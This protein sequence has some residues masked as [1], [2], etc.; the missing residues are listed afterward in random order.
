MGARGRAWCL[1]FAVLLC[2]V[3]SAFAQVVVNEVLPDPAGSDGGQEFVELYNPSG[4]PVSL[5][6][7]VVESWHGARRGWLRAWTGT[8]TDRC[9]ARGFFVLGGD[10]VTARVDGAFDETLTN[11]SGAVRVRGPRGVWSVVG[12]GALDDRQ[13]FEDTPAPAPGSAHSLS[14]VPDGANSGRTGADFLVTDAPTPGASNGRRGPVFASV[15]FAVAPGLPWPRRAATVRVRLGVV[16]GDAAPTAG[17]V[18][19][20]RAVSPS[21][22]DAD[23]GTPSLPATLV[24]RDTLELSVSWTPE[25]AG[26]WTIA[27]SLVVPDGDTL[28]V[29]RAVRVGLG[30]LVITEVMASPRS[31]DPEWI[32]C[33]N[34]SPADLP[35][36]GYTLVGPHGDEVSLPLRTLAPDE[37]VVLCNSAAKMVTAFA[38]V[39]QSRC[40]ELGSA[41]PSLPLRLAGSEQPA[42][43]AL[44]ARDGAWSDW[45]P[46]GAWRSSAGHAWERFDRALAPDD[47]LAWQLSTATEGGTPGAPN[48]AEPSSAA[49]PPSVS[50]DM[51]S[52]PTPIAVVDLGGAPC[53]GVLSVCALSGRRVADVTRFARV[54]GRMR[55]PVDVRAAHLAPGLYAVVLDV[56][57]G[58][59]GVVRRAASLAVAP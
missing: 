20:V 3:R 49:R 13:L 4:E 44:R 15:P 58:G 1:V 50:I 38:A 41:F 55:V 26:V 40:V 59:R 2:G 9:A 32:E 46:Y 21:G 7:V 51:A 57:G 54:R 10:A 28:H 17:F 53:D 22:A 14:R 39:V 19:R 37:R 31:G 6:G 5:A 48:S 36:G 18:L 52:G 29:A 30:P 27:A 8:S 47:P 33:W 25:I 56:R 45:A 24:A 12:W 43:C 11:A 23:L 35:L 42:A 34:A 16:G